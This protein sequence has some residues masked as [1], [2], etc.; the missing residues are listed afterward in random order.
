MILTQHLAVIRNGLTA[1]TP[2]NDMV[3]IHLIDG[4]DLSGVH[5]SLGNTVRAD[6]ALALIGFTTHRL[7]ERADAQ[8]LQL[9][10]AGEQVQ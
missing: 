3:S 2:R 9:S 8:G 4:P 6:T 10:T 1:L 5:A 7:T